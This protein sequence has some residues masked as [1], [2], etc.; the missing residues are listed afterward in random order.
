LAQKAS[1]HSLDELPPSC[2][3]ELY[4]EA[5]LDQVIDDG[6]AMLWARLA[7]H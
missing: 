3:I 1:Y 7:G 5:P 4:T 6:E 2:L